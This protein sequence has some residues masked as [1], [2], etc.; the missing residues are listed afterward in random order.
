MANSMVA[1][2]LSG[3][4]LDHPL[5]KRVLSSIDDLVLVQKEGVLV[6]PCVS[7]IWDT[8]LALGALLE[9]GLSPDSILIDRAMN[10]FRAK[11]V[12]LKGDWSVRVPACEPG[13][14]P[15]SL[16]MSIIPMWTTQPWC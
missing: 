4:S 1:L 6:Q 10:W 5:V 13:V 14:G 11:E 2:K 9:A 12:R 15:S 3:Y 7:P 16:K 8:S